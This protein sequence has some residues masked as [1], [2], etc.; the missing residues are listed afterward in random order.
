MTKEIKRRHPVKWDLETQIQWLKEQGIPNNYQ[1]MKYCREH[2][3][4][5][6]SGMPKNL[7]TYIKGRKI[8]GTVA[9]LYFDKV[10]KWGIPKIK[11]WLKDNRHKWLKDGEDDSI[12]KYEAWAKKNQE[13]LP[14]GMILNLEPYLYTRKAKGTAREIFFDKVWDI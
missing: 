2:K 6:P 1:Y 10:P 5:V 13:K 14:K 9:G 7:D 11:K 8:K 12:K 4:L 3:E